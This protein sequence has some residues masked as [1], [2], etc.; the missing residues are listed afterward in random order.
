MGSSDGRPGSRGVRLLEA[1]VASLREANHRLEA[2]LEDDK[3]KKALRVRLYD[4]SAPRR[5]APTSSTFAMCCRGGLRCCRA[6]AAPSSRSSPRPHPL[7]RDRRHQSCTMAQ[8]PGIGSWLGRRRRR[9][10]RRRILLRWV[11]PQRRSLRL[12]R[13]LHRASRPREPPMPTAATRMPAH[14]RGTSHRRALSCH[15]SQRSC[16]RPQCQ[17][18][19]QDSVGG[20]GGGGSIE[21]VAL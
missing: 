14:R 3:R 7:A 11:P 6:V 21:V 13:R 10:R 18:A 1:T 19:A 4:S 15:P 12:R 5:M 2:A 8:A 9:R 20:G 16:G 17:H